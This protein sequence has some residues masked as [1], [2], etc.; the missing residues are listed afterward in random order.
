MKAWLTKG[1]PEG[2]PIQNLP[3][4]LEHVWFANPVESVGLY[5]QLYKLKVRLKIPGDSTPIF[6]TFR[7]NES[8]PDSD[9]IYQGEKSIKTVENR[10]KVKLDKRERPLKTIFTFYTHSRN[11]QH[12]CLLSFVK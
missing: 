4:D 8:E 12:F 7:Q 1:S 9:P 11:W 3:G 10:Y 2:E 5:F 6:D